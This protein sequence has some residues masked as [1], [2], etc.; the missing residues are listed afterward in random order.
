MPLA[1]VLLESELPDVVLT[2]G[3][4][5]NERAPFQRP[6]PMTKSQPCF[7][8]AV[9]LL[10]T[11]AISLQAGEPV[12]ANEVAQAS[13]TSVADYLLEIAD[14]KIESASAKAQKS[15]IQL[16][17]IKQLYEQGHASFRELTDA[18]IEN[19]SLQAILRS[20]I[21]HR[22]HVASAAAAP[23][24]RINPESRAT[25]RAVVISIPGMIG[26]PAAD[27]VSRIVIP[28]GVD[29]ERAIELQVAVAKEFAS[30]RQSRAKAWNDL[31]NRLASLGTL[32]APTNETIFAKL[33][34]R[35]AIAEANL[36]RLASQTIQCLTIP[37]DRLDPLRSL[38][39]WFA[40]ANA[41][42][43]RCNHAALLQ[44]A[45]QEHAALQ[46]LLDRVQIAAKNNASP[47][48]ELRGIQ[49]RVASAA[50]RMQLQN[51]EPLTYLSKLSR[52]Q[53]DL[54]RQSVVEKMLA[55]VEAAELAKQRLRSEYQRNKKLQGLGAQ[56]SY[57]QNE[58][59]R[60]D[61]VLALAD[62]THRHAE[63]QH[64]QSVLQHDYVMARIGASGEATG[65]A[66]PKVWMRPLIELFTLRAK[67]HATE[68][69][70][71]RQH[72]LDQWRVDGLALLQ[73]QGATTW[74]EV[75]AADVNL[76][77]S[78][79]AAARAKVDRIVSAAIVQLLDASVKLAEPT[80]GN[81]LTAQSKDIAASESN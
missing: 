54:I 14:A 46:T 44:A 55:A 68:E 25:D 38:P 29:V 35:I 22:G 16:T 24:S 63:F 78:D 31:T 40:M 3:S 32:A 73:K 72:D 17:A 41:S 45:K 75:M 2:W 5:Q 21:E 67:S 74:K 42:V 28:S 18:T 33:N 11:Q 10:F 26:D 7:A 70:L 48:G 20:T 52:D 66:D 53:C 71:R 59:Y 62:A 9:V 1:L 6:V 56:D 51:S 76:A 30:H 61:L 36:E 60:S 43:L 80:P 50:Y 37:G 47:P 13:A 58:V 57:F 81:Q 15:E 49:Q 34:A 4:F 23:D 65:N 8:F 19:S 39:D 79:E 64:Q 12:K 69:M 27:W 77:E